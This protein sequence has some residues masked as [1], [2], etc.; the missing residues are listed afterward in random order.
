MSKPPT[1]QEVADYNKKRKEE[2][3][4]NRGSTNKFEDTFVADLLI[5]NY[6]LIVEVPEKHLHYGNP[7]KHPILGIVFDIYNEQS[8]SQSIRGAIILEKYANNIG[9]V[10]F[11]DEIFV[12]AEERGLLSMLINIVFRVDI[13]I[14]LSWDMEKKG[15]R[16]LLQRGIENGINM[17]ACLSRTNDL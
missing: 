6:E 4:F 3:H 12:V 9:K 13:D 14:F 15:I 16:Y 1:Y 17:S 11:L 7:E 10:N 8:P 5:F 2:R